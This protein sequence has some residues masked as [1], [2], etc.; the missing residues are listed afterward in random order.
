MKLYN[1]KEIGAILKLAAENSSVDE[2]NSQVGL[3]IDELSQLASEVGIDPK[4]ITRA[5]SEIEINSLRNEHNFWGGPF[6]YK[7]QIM[8]EG[9][10]TVGQWEEM[11]F[12]IRHYFK[13]KGKVTTRGSTF[14]WASSWDTSNSAQVTARKNSGKTN[15]S[16]NWHGPLTALPFYI[17]VPIV[18]IA[19]LLLASGFLELSSIPGIALTLLATGL[20]FFAGRWKLKKHLN[21]LFKKFRHMLTELEIIASRQPSQSEIELNQKERKRF[22]QKNEDHPLKNILIEDDQTEEDVGKKNQKRSIT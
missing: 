21:T 18:G 10:L 2:P 4:Q 11:L 15:I 7:N 8:V 16:M 22:Q 12:L 5:A 1:N 17:P 19:S 6:S 9:E 14:E 13:S 20:T 3:S